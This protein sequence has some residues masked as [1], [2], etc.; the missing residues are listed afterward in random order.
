LKHHYFK[1]YFTN[2]FMRRSPSRDCFW[3]WGSS[4]AES[5]TKT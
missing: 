4:P 2:S 1:C 5:G 3:I